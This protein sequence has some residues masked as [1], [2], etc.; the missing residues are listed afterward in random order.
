MAQ[1]YISLSHELNEKLKEVENASGLIQELLNKHFGDNR[2]DKEIIDEVKEKISD[3]ERAE[4]NKQEKINNVIKSA[5]DVF[6]ETLTEEQATEYLNSP[7]C[8]DLLHFI[9]NAN[10]NTFQNPIG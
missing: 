9:K 1:R 3:K 10:K 4:T 7:S 5:K 2:S 6:G 8:G